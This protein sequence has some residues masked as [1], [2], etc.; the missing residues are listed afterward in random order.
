MMLSLPH[1]PPSPYG[2]FVTCSGWP[3]TMSMVVV[4]IKLIVFYIG[5][6]YNYHID[7]DSRPEQGLGHFLEQLLRCPTFAMQSI[8][9][10]SL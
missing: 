10:A 9:T 7:Q 6:E 3:Y 8:A 2:I 4:Y 5:K 1:P